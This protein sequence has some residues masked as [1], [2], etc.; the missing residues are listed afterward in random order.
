MYQ[1]IIYQVDC[2]LLIRLRQLKG[3]RA[4]TYLDE[5]LKIP[6]NLVFIYCQIVIF[7]AFKEVVWRHKFE[8][9]CWMVLITLLN[10]SF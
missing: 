6:Q 4:K 5:V 8:I 1:T 3:L 9:G 7:V 2:F 10:Y